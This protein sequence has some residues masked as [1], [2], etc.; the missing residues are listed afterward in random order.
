MVVLL[1]LACGGCARRERHP[2]VIVISID[3]L[4][5]DHVSP[6]AT[7]H[8]D[9]LARDGIVFRNA[10]SHSPLTLPSHLSMLTGLL[11]PEHGVRDNAGYRF[12]AAAHPTL[13]GLL[14]A[15]GYRTGAAVSAYVPRGATGVSSGFDDFDDAIGIIDGAPLGALQRS[16][17]VTES[18]AET[19]IGAH[20]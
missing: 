5:A 20:D 19:W 14:R 18:I 17:D 16:G 7:P 10:W 15:N 8:I 4:R 2:P 13:A 3:T 1:L 9:A 11:P 6:R 12:D